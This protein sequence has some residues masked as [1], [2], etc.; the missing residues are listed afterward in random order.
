MMRALAVTAVAALLVMPGSLAG[1]VIASDS[2]SNAGYTS[3]TNSNGLNGGFGFKAWNLVGKPL[4]GGFSIG[5]SNEIGHSGSI[6]TSGTSFILNA[7]GAGDISDSGNTAVLE[8]PFS[9]QLAVGTEFNMNV[10]EGTSGVLQIALAGGSIIGANVTA[11]PN[12][13]WY[14]GDPYEDTAQDTGIPDTKAVRIEFDRKATTSYIII[15]SAID[16]SGSASGTYISNVNP[17]NI[18]MEMDEY[19]GFIPDATQ[20][21]A[22]NSLQVASLPE[23]N[24]FLI[25]AFFSVGILGRRKRS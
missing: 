11:G 21:I 3:G 1:A 9:S 7:A 8:R 16:G 4:Y 25:L 19:V 18:F 17:N 23:P 24:S 5:T 22:F 6:D 13:N 2:A 15:I 14:I 20:D 10:D 12:G